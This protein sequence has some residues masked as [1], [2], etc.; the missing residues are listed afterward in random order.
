[1]GWVS[2]NDRLPASDLDE[3]LCSDGDSFAIGSFW[4]KSQRFEFNSDFN[5]NCMLYWRHSA[6]VYWMEIPPTPK[7]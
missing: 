4:A 1:M 6:V 5:I 2:V 7:S 3:V